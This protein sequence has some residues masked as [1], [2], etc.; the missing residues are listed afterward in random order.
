MFLQLVRDVVGLLAVMKE[1]GSKLA[2]TWLGQNQI[3]ALI[4]L[5]G[6]GQGAISWAN[7]LH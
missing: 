3:G 4:G 1:I 6:L 2:G 7:S 5:E